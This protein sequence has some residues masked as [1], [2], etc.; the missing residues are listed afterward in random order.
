MKKARVAVIGA[1]PAGLFAAHLLHREGAEVALFESH[2]KAGGC[3]SYFRRKGD[4]G[5]ASFDAG[6]T[7]LNEMSEGRFL[8]RLLDHC[9]IEVPSRFRKNICVVFDL[10]GQS[11]FL[12]E[13]TSFESFEKSLA[14]AF[15]Q[16]AQGLRAFF[17]RYRAPVEALRESL[18]RVPHLPLERWQD[19]RL[20]WPAL[21]PLRALW[22]FAF[23]TRLSF[24]DICVRYNFSEALRR[25]IDMNFLITLQCPATDCFPLVGAYALCFYLWD[26]GSLEGGMRALFESMLKKLSE[27]APVFMRSP[28]AAIE[29][30][31][32]DFFLELSDKRRAG[33]F[34]IV[35]SSL[36][37]YDTA[38]IFR[39]PAAFGSAS[40]WESLDR[41]LW[42]A[43]VSY[44]VVK[45]SPELPSSPFNAHIR[46]AGHE[47]YVSFSGRNCPER[48]A[49]GLRTVTL[50]A[51]SRSAEWFP[52]GE[53]LAGPRYDRLKERRGEELLKAFRHS[54]AQIEIVFREHGSP[55]SFF[56]YT[57]RREGTVGG[58]P[59]SKAHS[60]WN[61]PSPRSFVP[62][63]YQIGDT[64]FPG[65]SV[66][67]TA[68][69]A[70]AVV[71]KIL[72]R[73]LSIK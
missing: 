56:K 24:A 14:A 67:G 62:Q 31:G 25:W 26:S 13:C 63:L 60:L 2:S 61:A 19:L 21:A 32:E 47:T 41:E 65:P 58:I 57:R 3:A 43:F 18:G 6:A 64:S 29:K 59:L 45:D 46:L 44:L 17:A 51:H 9:G 73:K 40:H 36:P 68:I 27:E 34:D 12:V 5:T 11:K 20:G 69:G 30:T 52:D 39:G 16:D 28:V 70:C 8:R 7:I 4:F 1:G 23:E 71:E 22:P 33:P 49:E 50:S 10:E 35:I 54:F 42:G 15:P 38:R 72:G 48:C 55:R 66:L 37:R 53:K